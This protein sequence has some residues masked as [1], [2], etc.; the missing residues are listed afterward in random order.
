MQRELSILRK[1]P[2]PGISCWPVDDQQIDKLY[3]GSE[4]IP[5]YSFVYTGFPLFILG[6]RCECTFDVESDDAQ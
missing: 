4:L 2:P 5:F 3:A 1:E 6:E